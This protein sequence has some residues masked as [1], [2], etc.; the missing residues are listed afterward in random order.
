MNI[1]QKRKIIG[2]KHKAQ[3]ILLC[4]ILGMHKWVSNA[5]KKRNPTAKQLAT[6]PE[7]FIDFCTIWCDRCG[8]HSKYADEMDKELLISLR[9]AKK[10]E[11][12]N[13]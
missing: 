10:E 6:F 3:R 13:D 9:N 8:K 7:G 11:A 1:Q 12:H 5:D 2:W 4:N